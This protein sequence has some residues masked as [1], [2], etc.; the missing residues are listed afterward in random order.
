MP[1]AIAGFTL[2]ASGAAVVVVKEPAGR[3]VVSPKANE[4]V[5]RMRHIHHNATTVT[6][7]LAADARIHVGSNTNATLADLAG[8]QIAHIHYTVENGNWL[9]HEIAV[10]PPHGHHLLKDVSGELRVHGPVVS[11][12]PS[13][14]L[15]TI[16]HSH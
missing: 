12:N 7:A 2:A 4:V 6:F 9:A 13:A 11:F 3:I 14:G 16:K 5:V 10:N 15:L 1:L 8:G